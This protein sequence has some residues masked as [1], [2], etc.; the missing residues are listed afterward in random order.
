MIV[1]EIRDRE[2]EK[3]R[4]VGGGRFWSWREGSQGRVLPVQ[5]REPEFRVPVPGTQGGL[6]VERDGS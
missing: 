2:R 3:E 6:E 1:M 4:G 5:T